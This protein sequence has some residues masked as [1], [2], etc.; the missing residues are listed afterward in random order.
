MSLLVAKGLSSPIQIFSG[1][2]PSQSRVPFLRFKRRGSESTAGCVP[3][4]SVLF[5]FT[6]RSSVS[7][8]L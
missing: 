1:K 8:S 6:K 3:R 7:A 4:E 2:S 5:M